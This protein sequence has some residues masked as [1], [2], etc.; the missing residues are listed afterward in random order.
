MFGWENLKPEQIPIN[1]MIWNR[2]PKCTFVGSTYTPTVLKLGVYDA[3]A[4]FNMGSGPAKK[5][6]LESRLDPGSY[7][8]QGIWRADKKQ[9]KKADYRA[10]PEAKKRRKAFQSQKKKKKDRNKV[11]EGKNIWSGSLLT[12]ILATLTSSQ[13]L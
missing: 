9:M 10:T 12:L 6:L 3:V 4:H 2:L 5:I 11:A 8:K 13:R 7:F 1:G